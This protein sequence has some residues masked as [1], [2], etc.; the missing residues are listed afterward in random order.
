MWTVRPTVFRRMVVVHPIRMTVTAGVHHSSSLGSDDVTP[1]HHQKKKMRKELHCD[2][3]DADQCDT[4]TSTTGN[5]PTTTTPTTTTTTTT[6]NTNTTMTS[7]IPDLYQRPLEVIYQDACMAIIHKPQGMT[8][9]GGRPSL[10]RS[11]LL[12]PLVGNNNNNNNNNNTPTLSP[13]DRILGKPRP[14]HRLD[15]AT[16]GLLVVAKTTYADR[17]LSMAFMNRACRKRY[18]ALLVGKLQISPDTTTTTTT[19]DTNTSSTLPPYTT[20]LDDHDSAPAAAEVVIQ[21]DVTGKTSQTYLRVVRHMWAPSVSSGHDD[22]YT[23]VDL[24]PVTGR[25]HQLRKHMKLIGYSIYGDTRYM[26]PAVLAAARSGTTT[27]TTVPPPP[28][29]LWAMEITVPHPYTGVDLT[30]VLPNHDDPD[31][32]HP[33]LFP[34]RTTNDDDND[35]R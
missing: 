29:C 15:S 18:R 8:V 31:W 33:V 14:A 22:W 20:R 26:A 11:D 7:T 2:D 32:F 24:W 4:V 23:M 17:Q 21:A 25:K 16:G 12:M 3:G 1:A 27:T 34:S 9:M 13:S 6:T 30:C 28:L 10:I 19:A 5:T 35:V